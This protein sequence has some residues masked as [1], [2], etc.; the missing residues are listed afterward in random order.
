LA[1]LAFEVV[2]EL[3]FW[4]TALIAHNRTTE[5]ISNGSFFMSFSLGFGRRPRADA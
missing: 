1:V 5:R 3:E 4:A 2:L